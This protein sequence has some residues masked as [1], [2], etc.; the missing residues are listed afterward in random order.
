MCDFP[1]L[2]ICQFG[3]CAFLALA[4]QLTTI[5]AVPKN[6]LNSSSPRNSEQRPSS[7]ASQHSSEALIVV[8]RR[9][10][11]SCECK[12]LAKIKMAKNR[13]QLPIFD[14]YP[15]NHGLTLGANS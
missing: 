7:L 9:V 10:N 1:L 5:F 14:R 6:A 4:R 8:D 12:H 11:T 2:V 13:C 3:M 15:R